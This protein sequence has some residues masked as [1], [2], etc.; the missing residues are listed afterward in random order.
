[1]DYPVGS[2]GYERELLLAK[3]EALPWWLY[4]AKWRLRRDLAVARERMFEQTKRGIERF[5]GYPEGR[6]D[7][8]GS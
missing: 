5:M 7:S 1:M 4:F 2:I 3:I 8:D 6:L